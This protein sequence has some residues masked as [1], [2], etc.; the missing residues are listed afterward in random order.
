MLC[1]SQSW[2]KKM[3]IS[4]L[5]LHSWQ[6]KLLHSSIRR[7]CHKSQRKWAGPLP[8]V[9]GINEWTD[10]EEWCRVAKHTDIQHT[11]Y[12]HTVHKHIHTHTNTQTPRTFSL[13]P[14]STDAV[15]RMS[16]RA[17]SPTLQHSR[18]S[19]HMHLAM[20]STSTNTSIASGAGL[21]EE[22]GEEIHTY[23][24]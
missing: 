15:S 21:D 22:E 9:V 2:P 11:M 10:E 1:S 16:P 6:T 18:S 7:P 23:S 17:I 20:A 13:S 12:I 8:T 19:R 3:H 5:T 14:T 4:E 24:T